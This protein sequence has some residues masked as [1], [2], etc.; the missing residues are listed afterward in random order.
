M[1]YEI[2]IL[3]AAVPVLDKAFAAQN[4]TRLTQGKTTFKTI[5][6]F[7]TAEIEKEFGISAEELEVL[8]TKETIADITAKIATLK[9]DSLTAIVAAIQAEVDK[10]GGV[11]VANP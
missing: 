1:K 8:Q 3:D 10:G 7:L 11:G 4:A 6:E 9:K 2:T 5:D